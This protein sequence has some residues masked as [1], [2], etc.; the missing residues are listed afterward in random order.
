MSTAST[1]PCI[2]SAKDRRAQRIVR[3][4]PIPRCSCVRL[5]FIP[6]QGWGGSFAVKR[7]HDSRY[8]RGF[9][10]G[11][12]LNSQN[13][14]PVAPQGLGDPSVATLVRF[15]LVAPE[16]GV[17]S[18]QVLAFATMPKAAV[19]KN[20]YFTARPSEI[21]L[22][23]YRPMFAVTPYTGSPEQLCNRQFGGCIA[24]R[25]DRGHDA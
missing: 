14:P 20:C 1:H 17:G 21:G 9:S 25:A 16:F 24:A 13:G 4:R 10:H 2:R 3:G 5:Y 7:S 12:F 8:G 22:T 18:W 11:A 15:N 19:H 6:P 23:D